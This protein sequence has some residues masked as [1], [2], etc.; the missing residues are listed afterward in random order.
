M[1]LST[2]A[3]RRR[4]LPSQQSS[5]AHKCQRIPKILVV[6]ALVWAQASSSAIS[7]VSLGLRSALGNSLLGRTQSKSRGRTTVSSSRQLGACRLAAWEDESGDDDDDDD[8]LDETLVE[9]AY[10]HASSPRDLARIRSVQYAQL[11]TDSRSLDGPASEL[12]L[13]ESTLP[14]SCRTVQQVSSR[15]TLS[16]DETT[17]RGGAVTEAALN[18]PLKFWENM[19]CG[20]V[21]RAVAQT[22][23]HPANTMK[24]ILQSSRGPDRPTLLEL[25]RPRSFRR[26]SRGAGANFIMSIPHGA[27]NFAVLEFVRKRL[28]DVVHATPFLEERAERFGAALDFLS[29]CISTITCSIVSTPQMVITDNIMAG[30]YPNL[31]AATRGIA[32]SS[33]VMGFYRGWVPG[34]VGKIPSYALTWTFFQ[35]L[36]VLHAHIAK[37]PSRDLENSIMGSIASATT[38]CI[39]IPMDTIKTRLVTQAGLAPELAYKGIIDCAVRVYRE[40]GLSTFYRGLPPRLLSVVPMIG[41]QFG[42]YE[43]A[44]RFMIERRAGEGRGGIN[45][46]GRQQVLEEAAMEV[47]ASPEQPEPAPHFLKRVAQNGLK[48][49]RRKK[50]KSLAR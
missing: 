24:T 22:V 37:R 26:L 45:R 49:K 19:V 13:L 15:Q 40:E 42:V 29:S 31:P 48:R 5:T 46:Y 35:R 4:P 21:S 32:K 10:F 39:M 20:A 23:M 36:K 7:P 44:K 14:P 3:R 43:F 34:L 12:D 47:A 30:N 38:V 11:K 41:I 17:N 6:C 9:P 28:N 27:V 50:K 2:R 16:A 25:A 18:S 8:E 1:I 33:G